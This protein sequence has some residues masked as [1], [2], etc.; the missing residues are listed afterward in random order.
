MQLAIVVPLLV[1]LLGLLTYALAANGKVAELG[2]LAFGAGLLVT[3]FSV[4]GHVLRL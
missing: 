4:A 1:C 3:L 2:R